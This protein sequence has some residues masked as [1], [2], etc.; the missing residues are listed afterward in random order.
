MKRKKWLLT[1]TMLVV[2]GSLWNVLG[3]PDVLVLLELPVTPLSFSK[4]PLFTIPQ[5]LEQIQDDSACYSNCAFFTQVRL[6]TSTCQVSN[7]KAGTST[8]F[9]LLQFPVGFLPLCS[10]ILH[11]SCGDLFLFSD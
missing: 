3:Q 8:K 4:Q 11:S 7:L 10:D 5:L 1:C 6:G 9:S 2:G